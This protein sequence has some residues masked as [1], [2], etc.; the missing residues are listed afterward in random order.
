MTDKILKDNRQIVLLW[1]WI[2]VILTWCWLRI[3]QPLL[4]SLGSDRCRC[5]ETWAGCRP[6]AAPCFLQTWSPQGKHNSFTSP[7]NTLYII[8]GALTEVVTSLK[9]NKDLTCLT[10]SLKLINHH[11]WSLISYDIYN[12]MQIL[13]DQRRVA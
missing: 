12:S 10:I 7:F 3:S 4:F 6:A 11:H 13:L 2:H 1:T 9:H 5:C 8:T